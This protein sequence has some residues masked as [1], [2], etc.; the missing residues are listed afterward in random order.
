MKERLDEAGVSIPFPQQGVHLVQESGQPNPFQ[1]QRRTRCTCGRDVRA[2]VACSLAPTC[3][4]GPGPRRPGPLTLN[5]PRPAQPSGSKPP[6]GRGGRRSGALFV[7]DS[8]GPASQ[9]L[10][11]PTTPPYH[12][13]GGVLV[14]P[15]PV[16]DAVG[17][18]R[19]RITGKL[20]TTIT[21]WAFAL[22]LVGAN[23]VWA[24][25]TICGGATG[26]DDEGTLI[27]NCGPGQCPGEEAPQCAELNAGTGIPPGEGTFDSGHPHEGKEYAWC[28]CPNET[29]SDCCHLVGVLDKGPPRKITEFFFVGT[30]IPCPLQGQC[31]ITNSPQ[32]I[33]AECD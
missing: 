21:L 7:S 16:L 15:L 13:T 8:Q 4:G 24:A 17:N 18:P 27:L 2:W 33:V 31:G 10:T 1:A 32:G 28:Q 26:N 22:V 29:E 25:P 30:C 11:P 5:P 23:G 20:D 9:R 12:L 6:L 19:E 14:C 3:Q